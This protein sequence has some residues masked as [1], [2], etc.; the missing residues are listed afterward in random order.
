VPCPLCREEFIIPDDGL[1]V[2][3]KNFFMEKLFHARKLSAGQEAQQIPC[4]VCSSD[5]ASASETVKPAS[6]YCVQCQQSYC[7]Q[8]SLHHRKMTSCSSY[9]QV[10]IGTGSKP[11]EMLKLSVNMC[12]EHNGKEIEVFCQ[13][14]KVAMCVMCVI[15]SHKTHDWINIEEVS[16]YLRS[17]VL[18][19]TH[20]VS[21]VLKITEDVL[22]RLEKEKN[23]VIEHLASTE[24]EINAAADKL[25]AAIQRDKV[26]LLSE[27]ESIKLKRVEQ[28][29]TVK[30][31]VE[32]HMTASESFKRY[33]E[34]LLSSGIA[35]DVTRSA[36]SLHDRAD[37]LMKFDVIGHIE[38][39]L[40][41]LDVTFTL[42]TL[43]DRDDRNIVGNL[44]KGQLEHVFVRKSE[45]SYYLYILFILVLCFCA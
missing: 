22:Q 2:T 9:T 27:V 26:K 13:D 31:E 16:E 41:P 28:V 3:Q 45:N 30:Q 18:S 19:D 12:E 37:E 14:C 34:T 38:S 35:G 29:E 20:K 33:S 6:M 40:P 4:D 25:I 17:L 32:Q 42:S 23:D 24:N 10:D 1:S 39:S 8:C 44:T 5:E 43:L 21:E 7:E 11:A 36:K 15:T